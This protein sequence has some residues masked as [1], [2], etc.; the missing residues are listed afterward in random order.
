[1]IG[2]ISVKGSKKNHRRFPGIKGKR[3]DLKALRQKEATERQAVYAA[4]P[5]TVRAERNPKK[6]AKLLA[7]NAA[8]KG[9]V[10]SPEMNSSHK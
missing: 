2:S 8:S 7:A 3:P 1:M 6:Q 4:L 5:V 10:L 9:P